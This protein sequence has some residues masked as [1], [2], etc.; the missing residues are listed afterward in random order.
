MRLRD[1]PGSA[2]SPAVIASWTWTTPAKARQKD[3]RFRSSKG[4]MNRCHALPALR[5]AEFLLPAWESALASDGHISREFHTCRLRSKPAW[6]PEGSEDRTSATAAES[7]WRW[8][9]ERATSAARRTSLC[10][11]CAAVAMQAAHDLRQHA[12][13]PSVPT[14][15]ILL[16]E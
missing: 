7:R 15:S 5:Y 12:V 11:S 14:L 13:Y 1:P 10:L 6:V 3:N 4:L 16:Q 2:P 8:I 9:P